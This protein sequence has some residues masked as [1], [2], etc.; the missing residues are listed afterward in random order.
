MQYEVHIGTS[1]ASR[2]ADR[3]VPASAERDRTPGVGLGTWG[4]NH[5]THICREGR[6]GEGDGV[7]PQIHSMRCDG[8]GSGAGEGPG[9][10]DGGAD[11]PCKPSWS[12]VWARPKI[13]G[14]CKVRA[15]RRLR[16]SSEYKATPILGTGAMPKTRKR[17]LTPDLEIAGVHKLGK[18]GNE[19]DAASPTY[20]ESR[21]SFHPILQQPE[22]HKRPRPKNKIE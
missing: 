7:G 1:R 21:L 18:G 9:A 5:G 2:P 13:V 16:P 17:G 22:G 15:P 20:A 4:H 8:V 10:T 11:L 3:K 12:D 6:G 14:P 19:T